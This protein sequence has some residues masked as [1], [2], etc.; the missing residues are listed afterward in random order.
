MPF[1]ATSPVGPIPVTVEPVMVQ[2]V[3]ASSQVMPFLSYAVTASLL[4]ETF[5]VNPASDAT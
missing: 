3:P 5:E 1:C 4:M 2:V